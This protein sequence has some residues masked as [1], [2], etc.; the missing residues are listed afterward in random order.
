MSVQASARSWTSALARSTRPNTRRHPLP[1]RPQEQRRK[2]SCRYNHPRTQRVHGVRK[3]RHQ[4]RRDGQQLQSELHGSACSTSTIIA[5]PVFNS[6]HTH[7][8]NG[9]TSWDPRVH[10]AQRHTTIAIHSCIPIAVLSV[11]AAERTLSYAEWCDRFAYTAAT[12]AHQC[13]PRTR[14]QRRGTKWEENVV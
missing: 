1:R 12:R 4:R 13:V 2:P 11:S 6:M 14:R 8:R 10:A 9:S 5:C 3:P 7:L